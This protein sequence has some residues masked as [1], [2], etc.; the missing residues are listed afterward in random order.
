[1]RLARSIV[2]ALVLAGCVPPPSSPDAGVVP[3]GTVDA[4]CE[5][6]KA[7]GCPEGQD[8]ACPRTLQNLR[9]RPIIAIN[10]ACVMRA[11]TATDAAACAG[12]RCRVE[13]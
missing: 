1:M 5:K 7:L 6:L 8:P 9:I 13:P 11:A 2:I 12:F 3:S 4:T 10:E